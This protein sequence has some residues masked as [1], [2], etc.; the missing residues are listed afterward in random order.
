MRFRTS[1]CSGLGLKAFWGLRWLWT[2]ACRAGCGGFR[3]G[4]K[5]AVNNHETTE[6]NLHK[7]FTQDFTKALAQQH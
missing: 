3:R 2:Q 1:A 4:T 6:L 5:R 7:T